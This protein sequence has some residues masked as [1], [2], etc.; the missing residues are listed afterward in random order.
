MDENGLNTKEQF[1]VLIVS[2]IVGFAASKFTEN[3][4]TKFLLSRKA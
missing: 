2:T 4:T 3:G 1:V